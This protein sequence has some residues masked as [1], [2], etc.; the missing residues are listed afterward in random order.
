M[1]QNKGKKSNKK[2]GQMFEN[3]VQK[4]INSGQLDFDKGDLKTDEHLIECKFTEKKGYRI[5]TKL[6]EKLWEEA[7][8]AQKLPILEIGIEDT[9]YRWMLTVHINKEIKR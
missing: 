9:D 4:T 5:T 3:K 7:L 6:L 1:P 8:T 2:K